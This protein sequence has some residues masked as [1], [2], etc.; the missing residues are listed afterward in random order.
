MFTGSHKDYDINRQYQ[1]EMR[2]AADRARLVQVIDEESEESTFNTRKWIM[3]GIIIGLAFVTLFA[4]LQR[5][6][7]QDAVNPGSGEPFHD[8]ML[9]YRVG[10]YFLN[11]GDYDRA[12]EKLSEAVAQMPEWAFQVQPAY[13]DLYWTLG[14]ALEGAGRYQEALVNYRAFHRWVGDEAAPWTF[15]KVEKLQ[16]QVDALLI[17]DTRL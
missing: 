9:A 16:A 10:I 7:A 4:G 8:A 11:K 14:E 3:V 15:V 17:E 13:A 1:D 6:F 2:D 12:T 5:A